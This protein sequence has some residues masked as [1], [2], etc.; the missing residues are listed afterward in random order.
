MRQLTFS[1]QFTKSKEHWPSFVALVQ[2]L[3]HVRTFVMPWTAARLA[4]LLSLTPRVCSNLCPLS[5]WC[6]PTI[7]SSLTPFS[8]CPQSFQASGSFPMYCLFPSGSQSIGASALSISPSNE[9]SG[10][11]SFRI[12]WFDLFTVQETQESSPAPQFESISS[13]HQLDLLY[14][15]TLTSIHDYWKNYSFDYMDLCR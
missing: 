10:L 13:E 14:G 6:H 12:N 1:Y 4:S 11:I 9:Y 5:R 15:P 2:S 7:S 8:S 3:S